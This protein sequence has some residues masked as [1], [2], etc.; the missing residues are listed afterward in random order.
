MLDKPSP[1][2]P[3]YG[4]PEGAAER[5]TAIVGESHAFSAS[6]DVAPYVAEQ[7]GLLNGVSPLVL[8][9]GSVEEVAAILRL[10][11]ALRV[12]VVPQGG[13]TGLVGGGV[14]R[15]AAG[16]LPAE[17][18][19]SLQ[20]MNR[21]LDVDTAGNTMLVEAGCVLQRAQEAADAADRLFPLSLGAQ[22][23]AQIGGNI[24]TNAGGT[25]VLAY[26]NTRDLVMGLE[27]VLPTGEVLDRLSRLRKDNTG[28]RLSELFV[29]AEGTLGIV[30]KAVLKLFPRPKGREVAFVAVPSPQA[31]LALFERARGAAGPQLT[32]FE[33]ISARAF[34]FTLEFADMRSPLAEP[35]PW[36]VLTEIS[37]GRSAE[38]A[39]EML[40]SVLMAAIEAGE[41]GDAA[42]AESLAQAGHVLEAARGHELV[43][44]A[45]RRLD[46]ARHLRAR[47][48]DP[49]FIDEADRGRAAR[50][51]RGPRRQFRPHGRRQPAL[52][53]H[54]PRGLGG[55]RPSST[56]TR[57]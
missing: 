33:L 17:I 25:G 32:A 5:F 15:G 2:L 44:E 39:R 9:P 7:R 40:E 24:A 56:S 55:R 50:V 12:P 13:N 20:R 54:P 29:G 14:P 28:Y 49:A 3:P 51:P 27:V 52:Q 36:Y 18:V 38:D 41:A 23:T 19:V 43:A 22:G 47:R 48:R 57:R 16:N 53:R 34:D 26:G 10:A 42:L 37:S 31:A 21:V 1:Q 4:L 45:A 46:Q 8:R 6:D 35:S 11:N 30:T